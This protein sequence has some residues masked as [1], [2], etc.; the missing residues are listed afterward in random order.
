MTSKHQSYHIISYHIICTNH[1]L[2]RRIEG[3]LIAN[4]V[5]VVELREKGGGR[6]DRPAVKRS[7]FYWG[8]DSHGSPQAIFH[9]GA[10]FAGII[11]ERRRVST[12]RSRHSRPG[13][14]ASG[15]QKKR[16]T[17]AGDEA[18]EEVAVDGSGDRFK[19]WPYSGLTIFLSPTKQGSA[20]DTA[21]VVVLGQ[22]VEALEWED[23]GGAT[24]GMMQRAAGS[25]SFREALSVAVQVTRPQDPPDMWRDSST[26]LQLPSDINGRGTFRWM[27]VAAASG[28]PFAAES[29]FLY[30]LGSYDMQGEPSLRTNSSSGGGS[31]GS[32]FAD[33]S[34]FD[35]FAVSR[36]HRTQVVGRVRAGALLA[37]DLL[38][39]E[40]LTAASDPSQA[41]SFVSLSQLTGETPPQPMAVLPGVVAEASLHFDARSSR[42]VVASLEASESYLRLCRSQDSNLAGTWECVAVAG[43][44][45]PWSD[46]H[47][48][49]AYA[50]RAHPELDPLTGEGGVLSFAT[51]L[52]TG[53]N[54]LF[55][56][57][58]LLAYCPLFLE[59]KFPN[60]L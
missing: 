51:N 16:R 34:L 2:R 31:S 39:F 11:T 28:R 24:E 38:A 12:S 9:S 6:A 23:D 55:Q 21:R 8:S 18:A 29:D 13:G 41:R 48:F 10:L 50:G 49:I 53:P 33:K 40:L 42:W 35:I 25:L 4:S 1:F 30:V 57:D 54:D 27:A 37:G 20:D 14:G 44:A 59:Y 56:P 58:N 52:L 26:A 22:L 46:K 45:A 19:F 5:A 15:R 32:L 36:S 47:R 43:I 17:S 3:E 60:Y 7:H